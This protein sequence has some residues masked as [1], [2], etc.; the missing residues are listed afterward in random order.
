[1]RAILRRT[2]ADQTAKCGRFAHTNLRRRCTSSSPNHERPLSSVQQMDSHDNS[3]SG[4]PNDPRVVREQ[5]A[6]NRLTLTE[7]E[8]MALLASID[9]QLAEIDAR[10]SS[11]E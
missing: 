7:D 11:Q 2:T 10:Q 4:H 5:L 8:R 6:K 3:G 1:M 9:R